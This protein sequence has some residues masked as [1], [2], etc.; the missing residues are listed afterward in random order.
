SLIGDLS[1]LFPTGIPTTILPTATGVN[2][3]VP[4]PTEV[5]SVVSNLPSS[6]PASKLSSIISDLN[7]I[8]TNVL[9]TNTIPNLPTC[10]P[11]NPVC[12][13]PPEAC[14]KIGEISDINAAIE[15]PA[16]VLECTT[17]LGPY[18]DDFYVG[19]CLGNI[20]Q[21]PTNLLAC[22]TNALS[23]VCITSLPGACTNLLGEPAEQLATA[24]PQCALALGP[25][26]VDDANKC[27]TG[28]LTSGDAVVSCLEKSLGLSACVPTASGQSTS[29][30]NLATETG[31]LP[32]PSEVQSILSEVTVSVPVTKLSSVIDDIGS[33]I[34]NVLPTNTLPSLATCTPGPPVCASV[35]DACEAIGNINGIAAAIE[36][37]AQIVKCTT[38]LGAFATN[39]AAAACLANVAQGPTA[40][41]NCLRTSLESVCITELPAACTNLAGASV[42]E[43]ATDAPEC[44]LALGPFLVNDA[45]NCLN[46]LE[47]GPDVVACLQKQIGLTVCSPTASGLSSAAGNLATQTGV[48]PL[49]SE[50]QS[51]LDQVTTLLPTLPT[52]PTLPV[53]SIETVVDGVTTLV[54][55]LPVSVP[56]AEISSIIG[57]IGS[58]ISN[59]LPTNT[60]PSLATCTPGPPVCASVPDACEAIG[61][62]GG[63]TAAIELPAQIAKCTTSLG[64]F[65]TNPA[66]A[67]CLANVVQGPT[68]I[69]N[70]LRTSLESVCI[71]ELPAACT[72][73]SGAPVTELATDAPQCALALGPFLVNDAQNCLNV[74]ESGPDVVACLQKQI[75]LAACPVMGKSHT[76]RSRSFRGSEQE[77]LI[78]IVRR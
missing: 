63:L 11:G 44:A 57:D 29:V 76:L 28:T 52:L 33:V 22:V 23:D 4:L 19:I 70:C 9:P 41:L 64:A 58:V 26:L 18:A 65:A 54:P 21:G 61:N 71:T 72:N 24:A 16:Q 34:S 1:T 12:A 43:L 53:Q 77:A 50:V 39:P 55:S 38:S 47:S 45:A 7:S 27:L 67:A 37:P 14:R 48:L 17:A 78:I 56:V 32:L 59:V 42:P 36:L 75:G 51:I 73:L 68:A 60:L 74:L 13:T 8:V 69:L 3:S 15:L 66:A 2:S 35:P 62:I 6:I 31:V 10:A 20:A 5:E 49:P 46:V 40:I 25:F 30:G